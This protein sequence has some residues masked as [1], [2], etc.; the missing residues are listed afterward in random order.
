M[1]DQKQVKDSSATEPEISPKNGKIR[2]KL[3]TPL[4]EAFI[5]EADK[6][7][8]PALDGDIMILPNRA[9]IFF[10]LRPGRMTVY[11][12][13]EDPI[14]FFVSS[15][16]CEVRRNLCPVMAWGARAD[17]INPERIKKQLDAAL[18][19]LPTTHSVAKMEALSRIDF[20]KMIL[21]ELGFDDDKV[22]EQSK[23]AKENL[24][25]MPEDFGVDTQ[26]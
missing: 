2:V 19:A 21:E 14:D 16:V 17:K 8:L 10:S 20:F 26:K 4:F 15:G 1:L 25:M 12:K 13:G 11:N 7:L 3:I 5:V 24:K 18:K 6:V 22:V 23:Q 9:P